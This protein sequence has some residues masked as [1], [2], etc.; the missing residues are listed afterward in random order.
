MNKLE[1]IAAERRA[2]FKK[3]AGSVNM[4]ELDR[5]IWARRPRSLHC[6]LA[7]AQAGKPV[8]IA[9][10]KKASPSA[11]LLCKD[12]DPAATARRYEAAGA[13]AISVLTEP[14]HFLGRGK[15]LA[16]VREAVS[17]PLLC[18]D[19]MVD[20]LQIAY[21]AAWGADVILLIA[22]LLT[23]SEMREMNGRAADLGL[24]VLCEAHT[25]EE[26]ERSLKLEGVMIG[27][28]SRD[29]KTLKTDL[30]IARNLGAQIPADRMAVAESGIRTA[31]EIQELMGLGYRGFLIG[32]SLLRGG[33]PG[34]ALSRIF[35][36]LKEPPRDGI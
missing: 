28:N 8:V 27:V 11:G 13:S 14:R 23:D 10:T 3:L 36:A 18:K 1:Q 6:R 22:A 31:A 12:Y 20:P 7:A 29:L 24:E 30:A 17:L 19:F 35:E 16:L 33:D 9:E 26:V 4:T 34:Q 32:E 15:D 2:D 21:A 5:Q 25:L